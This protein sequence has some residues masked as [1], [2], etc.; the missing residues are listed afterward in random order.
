MTAAEDAL[1]QLDA[2]LVEYNR[3][4]KASKPG[5]VSKEE[6]TTASR[7]LAAIERLTEPDSSYAREAEQLRTLTSSGAKV[8]RLATLA[9]ALRDDIRD[10]YTSSVIEL[11]GLRP[12]PS[13]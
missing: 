9:A 5:F 4:A 3:M 1:K 12:S 6:L 7:L 8:Y 13:R 10:G 2:L 11:A